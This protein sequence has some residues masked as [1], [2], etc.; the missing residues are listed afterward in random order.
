MIWT[1]SEAEEADTIE[2]KN[3]ESALTVGD[4]IEIEGLDKYVLTIEKKDGGDKLNVTIEDNINRLSSEFSEPHV[5]RKNGEIRLEAK[6]LKS[7]MMKGPELR[8]SL[9]SHGDDSLVSINIAKGKKPVFA[10]DIR[11][12]N[13]D[14]KKLALYISENFAISS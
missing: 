11:L 10:D 13:S 1:P 8:M 2:K 14:A 12:R 6:P 7:F 9:I 5:S 4:R 3:Q